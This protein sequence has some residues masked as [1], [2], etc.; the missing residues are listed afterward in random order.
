MWSNMIL[1]FLLFIFFLK[2]IFIWFSWLHIYSRK[3]EITEKYLEEIKI[4]IIHNYTTP[5][6]TWLVFCIFLFANAFTFKV[7][8]IFAYAVLCP[9]KI[10]WCQ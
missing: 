10:L 6:Q 9:V 5:K 7:K 2:F 1:I 3:L 4:K 8:D